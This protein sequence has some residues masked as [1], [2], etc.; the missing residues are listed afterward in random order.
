MNA[1]LRT[2]ATGLSRRRL[3]VL[4]AGGFA[5]A[6]GIAAVQTTGSQGAAPIAPAPFETRMFEAAALPADAPCAAV[7]T[8]D[9]AY[10]AYAA[11][12]AALAAGTAAAEVPHLDCFLPGAEDG[13]A[14]ALA[15][16]RTTVFDADV[17]YGFLDRRFERTLASALRVGQDRESELAKATDRFGTAALIA[18][19]RT[20][21]TRFLDLFRAYFDRLMQISDRALG[22]HDDFH[23][24]VM[25]GWGASN[26]V[27]DRWV[28]HVTHFGNFMAPAT[29]FARAVLEDPDLAEHADWARQIVDFH[30]SAWRQ[31]DADL[32][33][34]PGSELQ[35]YWRP[36]KDKFEATNHVHM[37]G[38][39]LLNVHAVTGDP[40]YAERIR[41]ILDAFEAG[42]TLHPDGT[43]SW[44]YSPH[45]QVEDA[46]SDRMSRQP[47]EHTWKGAATVPFLYLAA[48]DGFRLSPE[49]EAAVTKTIATHVVAGPGLTLHVHPEG[50][51]QLTPEDLATYPGLGGVFGGY[52]FAAL[53]DPGIEAQ[54][55]AI[56]AAASDLFPGGWFTAGRLAASY[57]TLLPGLAAD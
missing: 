43:A 36:L 20:G 34:V 17:L 32:R 4:A 28:V 51:R 49:V 53:A 11:I 14:G 56:V 44:R 22:W 15:A 35:W 48:R 54:I 50:S 27:K 24:R 21:E 33:P 9:H 46:L 13:A 3:L 31:F 42:V 38:V 12:D 18:F 47:S 52:H 23:G 16:F 30:R 57:A 6:V 29:G 5:L 19:H 40:L 7:R 25:D 8:P 45:F 26:L 10:P 41:A 2:L 37:Q 39:A 1:A 55:L